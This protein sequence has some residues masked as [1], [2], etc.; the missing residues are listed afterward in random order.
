MD[1]GRVLSRSYQTVQVGTSYLVNLVYSLK[2]LVEPL[3]NDPDIRG[4]CGSAI[5]SIMLYTDLH[6]RHGY[7]V[8]L[9]IRMPGF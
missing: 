1:N 8:S 9:K 6:N 3:V 2:C 7:G 5:P 4:L